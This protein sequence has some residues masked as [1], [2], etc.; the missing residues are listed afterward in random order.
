MQYGTVKKWDRTRG[1]G[2]ILGDDDE[3]YFVHINDLDP[4]LRGK[5]LEEGQRV[6][7]DVRPDVKGDRAVNVR[8]LY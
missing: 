1:F 2:F 5:D 4:S 3:E 8:L 7:F 6:A